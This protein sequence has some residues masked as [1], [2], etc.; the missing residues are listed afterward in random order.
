M[1]YVCLY[2]HI[3]SQGAVI[4]NERKC[5]YITH[6]LVHK[7]AYAVG[8]LLGKSLIYIHNVSVESTT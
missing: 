5:V 6:S 4:Y 1:R 2:V 3:R 7:R 8:M